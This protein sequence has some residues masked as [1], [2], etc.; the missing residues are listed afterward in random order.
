MKGASGF[1][2]AFHSGG[3]SFIF[4][5][6]SLLDGFGDAG[7]LLINNAAGADIGMPYLAVAHLPVR[8]ADIHAGSADPRNGVGGKNPVNIGLVRRLDGVALFLAPAAKAV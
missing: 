5:E 7:E 2:A 6:I 3:E 8:Q 4:K 1:F